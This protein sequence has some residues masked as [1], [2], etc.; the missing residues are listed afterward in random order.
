MGLCPSFHEQQFNVFA[1]HK[2]E[3]CLETFLFS[4]P[5]LNTDVC[6]MVSFHLLYMLV[7]S[8]S[9]YFIRAELKRILKGRRLG[10]HVSY[11]DVYRTS[12]ALF[13]LF[14]YSLLCLFVLFCFVLF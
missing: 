10:E 3:M 12:S 6:I 4:S 11:L 8:S 14:T 2:G 9:D 1:Q 13:C 7:V 5:S